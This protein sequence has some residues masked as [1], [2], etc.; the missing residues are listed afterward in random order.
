VITAQCDGELD[1]HLLIAD[2]RGPARR[3]RGNRWQH[4]RFEDCVRTICSFSD[5]SGRLAEAREAS[6]R[7]LR[8]RLRWM[9][10]EG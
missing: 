5:E 4:D 9:V 2:V 7:V 1:R 3:R 6:Q 8:E 10:A